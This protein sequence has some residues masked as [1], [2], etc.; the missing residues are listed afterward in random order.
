MH[1]HMNLKFAPLGIFAPHHTITSKG[2]LLLCE[3]GVTVDRA[4]AAILFQCVYSCIHSH[5][6]S[7]L[8]TQLHV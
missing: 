2:R 6:F 3:N 5:T 8:C 4:R 7:T 1:G